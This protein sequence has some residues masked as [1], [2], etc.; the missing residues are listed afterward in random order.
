MG[1]ESNQEAGSVSKAKLSGPYTVIR[2]LSEVLYKL[3]SRP[4]RQRSVV[5][6]YNQIKLCVFTGQK[7]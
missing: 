5:V 2:K 7:Q 4:R 3:A 1:T 6:V